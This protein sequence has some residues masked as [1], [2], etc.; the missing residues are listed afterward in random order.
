MPASVQ[1]NILKKDITDMTLKNNAYS[2]I[3][4]LPIIDFQ[5]SS[6]P[7]VE[8]GRKNGGMRMRLPVRDSEKHVPV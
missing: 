7:I 3:H 1:E 4:I 8:N 5:M 2:K 6:L